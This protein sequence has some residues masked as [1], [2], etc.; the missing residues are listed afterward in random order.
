LTAIAGKAGVASEVSAPSIQDR[1]AAIRAKVAQ[2]S[3]A[4]LHDV[5]TPA[6]GQ[7]ARVAWNDWKNE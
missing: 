4:R 7:P 2:L 3:T 1:V 5:V 6:I